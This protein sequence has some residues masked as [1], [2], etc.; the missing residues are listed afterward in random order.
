[1]LWTLTVVLALLVYSSLPIQGESRPMKE[2]EQYIVS[3]PSFWSPNPV[4]N[5]TLLKA[6]PTICSAYRP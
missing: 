4:L 6:D 3:I 2:E 5:I 1:M